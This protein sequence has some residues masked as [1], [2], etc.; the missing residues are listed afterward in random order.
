[1]VQLN[2]LLHVAQSKFNPYKREIVCRG[3]DIRQAAP[4]AMC[5]CMSLTGN[6]SVK[7][8]LVLLYICVTWS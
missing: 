7:L 8:L 6:L 5:S 1:L 3:I 2:A 4:A